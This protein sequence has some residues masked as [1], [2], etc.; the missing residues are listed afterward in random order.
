MSWASNSDGKVP[1]LN[2]PDQSKKTP[3]KKASKKRGKKKRAHYAEGSLLHPSFLPAKEL[4]LGEYLEGKSENDINS[5]I[6]GGLQLVIKNKQDEQARLKF[7]EAAQYGSP[8]AMFHLGNYYKETNKDEAYK[9][10]FLAFQRKW[11]T[12]G[13]IDDNW[14][15][16]LMQY[17]VGEGE[18]FLLLKTTFHPFNP[19]ALDDRGKFE[20]FRRFNTVYQTYEANFIETHLA[21]EEKNLKKAHL[22]DVISQINPSRDAIFYN[23]YREYLH[24]LA[25]LYLNK[26][27]STNYEKIRSLFEKADVPESNY[28]LGIMYVE[29][30]IGKDLSSDE[31]NQ[32]AKDLFEQ[33]GTSD[34]KF[35]LG[36]MHWEGLVGKD[37]TEDQRYEKAAQYFKE[38]R[39]SDRLYPDALYNL[40]FMYIKGLIGPTTSNEEREIV[41]AQLFEESNTP[42]AKCL[43][44]LMYLHNQA[45]KNLSQNNRIVKAKQLLEGSNT[46]KA[47]YNLGTV[48]LEEGKEGTESKQLFIKAE[49]CFENSNF[50]EALCNLGFMY[51]N[52]LAGLDISQ[53]ERIQKAEELFKKSQNWTA[54][55]NLVI[56]Y[57]QKLLQ[58]SDS[59]EEKILESLKKTFDE[60]GDAPVAKYGKAFLMAFFPEYI[61]SSASKQERYQEASEL[62]N[63][64]LN[65]GVFEAQELMD[66]ITTK[67]KKKPIENKAGKINQTVSLVPEQKTVSVYRETEFKTGLAEI[68]RRQIKKEKPKVEKGT[69]RKE[70][71][72]QLKRSFAQMKALSSPIVDP[73]RIILAFVT[74]KVEKSFKNFEQTTRKIRELIADIR[75][76]PWGTEGAGKPEILRNG[77]YKG[78]YSRRIDSEHRLIYKYL[79]LEDKIMIYQCGGHYQ[80]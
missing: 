66:Q 25:C 61:G 16:I 8:Q 18:P 42:P 20:K 65:Q 6:M 31:R 57:V 69:K 79:S 77:R 23:T 35:N 22:L 21:E 76:N 68:T 32:K 47:N 33:A 71:L 58:G 7:E 41:A 50:P 2:E 3:V 11:E 59:E 53:E 19:T 43:L 34:A 5:L 44:G 70:R 75:E 1:N 4:F 9:W 63:E 52:G 37:L 13:V 29:G 30:K 28:N 60:I 56:L 54:K 39:P 74:E 62:A 73:S 14:A 55:N 26:L 67:L 64:A 78:Y 38:L 40:G 17:S 10:Y 12:T 36:V 24:K 45:G 72:E 48:Y 49:K 27:K 51:L 15:D 80:D 46:S